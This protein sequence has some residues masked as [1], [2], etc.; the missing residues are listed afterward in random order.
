[1]LLLLF[2]I[3]VVDVAV[4]VAAVAAAVPFCQRASLLHAFVLL[5]ICFI[6]KAVILFFVHTGCSIVHSALINCHILNE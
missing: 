6:A 5:R 3:V 2:L 4:V 1:M